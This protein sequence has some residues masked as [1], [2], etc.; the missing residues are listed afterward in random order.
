[1]TVSADNKGDSRQALKI[2]FLNSFFGSEEYSIAAL[3]ADASFRTYD[4]ITLKNKSFILFY[5]NELPYISLRFNTF[6]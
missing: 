4:R 2:E 1:M 6:Y 5:L 3:L